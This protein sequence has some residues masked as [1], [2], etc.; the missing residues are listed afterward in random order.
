MNAT[1]AIRKTIVTIMALEIVAAGESAGRFF[2]RRFFFFIAKIVL[3]HEKDPLVMQLPA[4][5]KSQP[6][7]RP[8]RPPM[9][10]GNQFP[11]RRSLTQGVGGG[12]PQ[13][14]G[15]AGT[16]DIAAWRKSGTPG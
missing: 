4:A 8:Y 12:G 7:C 13:A 15:A 10:V 16:T 14:G 9:D 5:L 3:V 2:F 11:G 6:S 1:A